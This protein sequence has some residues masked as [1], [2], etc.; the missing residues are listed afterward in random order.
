MIKKIVK[1]SV[2]GVMFGFT[3]MTL[4]LLVIVLISNDLS[5]IV[6]K[7]SILSSIIVSAIVGITF[8]VGSLVYDSKLPRI[9]QTL[10]HMGVGMTVFFIGAYFAKWIPM[11]AG[12]PAVL[13]FIIFAFVVSFAIWGGFLIYYHLE[14][15]SIYKQLKNKEKATHN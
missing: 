14:A 7:E 9:L 15:K 1:Q 10:I 12:L 8:N 4:S 11:E 6:T 13:G 5:Q 3:M 2:I